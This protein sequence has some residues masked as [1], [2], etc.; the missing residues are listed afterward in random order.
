VVESGRSHAVLVGGFIL[1]NLASC[2]EM[3]DRSAREN[4]E[5]YAGCLTCAREIERGRLASCRSTEPLTLSIKGGTAM[6]PIHRPDPDAIAPP[7]CSREP[8]PYQFFSIMLISS[9]SL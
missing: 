1:Q 6:A 4:L 8:V 7:L 2:L 3:V 5:N 9:S